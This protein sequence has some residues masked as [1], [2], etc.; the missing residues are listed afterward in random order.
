MA[1]AA[2]SSDSDVD[3]PQ[4]IDVMQGKSEADNS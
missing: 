2:C 3:D 4:A 1:V